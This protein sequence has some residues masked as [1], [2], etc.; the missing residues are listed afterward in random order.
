MVSYRK[1]IDRTSNGYILIANILDKWLDFAS[2]SVSDLEW[3]IP[4]ENAAIIQYIL[5]KQR[6]Y[7]EPNGGEDNIVN[8]T[9]NRSFPISHM[10]EYHYLLKKP[11]ELSAYLKKIRIPGAK[12]Y[13]IEITNIFN[14]VKG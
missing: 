3:L 13:F 9:P 12:K 2:I 5:E 4:H 7:T 8:E 10:I 1:K 6:V 14:S 11:S